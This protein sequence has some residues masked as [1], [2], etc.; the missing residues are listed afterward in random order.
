LSQAEPIELL[1]LAP[2]ARWVFHAQALWRFVAFWVPVTVLGGFAGAVAFSAFWAAI[3]AGVWLMLM[4]L[5]AIWYP[6]LAFDRWG[7]AL[8]EGDLLIARGVVWH[9]V[10]AIPT[11][12]IQHVDTHQGPLEQW[13]GLA[14]VAIFTASGLGADGVIPGLTLEAAD[15]L[16]DTLVR[17]SVG[18]DDGV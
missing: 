15:A 6:S 16:R 17:A 12:R 8:R 9:T 3:V 10:V 13:F 14:R 1:P 2:R 18:E 11:H 7:Y 4:F 5:L